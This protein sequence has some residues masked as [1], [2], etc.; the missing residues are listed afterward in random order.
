MTSQP[1]DTCSRASVTAPP[2]ELLGSVGQFLCPEGGG[3]LVVHNP[4]SD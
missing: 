3:G 2:D 1:S 4:K